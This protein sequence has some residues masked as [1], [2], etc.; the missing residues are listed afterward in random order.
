MPKRSPPQDPRLALAG[1]PAVNL[2]DVSS[3]ALLA[4]CK[5]RFG[6]QLVFLTTDELVAEIK[7]RSIGCMVVTIAA[8]EGNYELWETAIKGS[9][10][11]VGAMSVRLEL[12]LHVD[13]QRHPEAS[14]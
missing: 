8:G 9:N 14:A 7:R 4:E 3:L 2:P 6:H 11:L 12:A 1:S 10:F 5:R 13:R